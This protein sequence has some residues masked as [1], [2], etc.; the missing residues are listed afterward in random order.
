MRVREL[1][2]II[3]LRRKMQPFVDP[4]LQE[5]RG[6]NQNRRAAENGKPLPAQAVEQ[7]DRYPDRNEDEHDACLELHAD[8]GDQ[9]HQ[10]EQQ[11][12][13]NRFVALQ[14]CIQEDRQHDQRQP[15]RIGI[16]DRRIEPEW[17]IEQQKAAAKERKV[18]AAGALNGKEAQHGGRQDRGAVQ[19]HRPLME[20]LGTDVRRYPQNDPCKQGQDQQ[21]KLIVFILR[22][23]TV[24]DRAFPACSTERVDVQ[25]RKVPCVH[26]VCQPQPIGKIQHQKQRNGAGAQEG[27]RQN[28]T[29]DPMEQ[30]AAFSPHKQQGKK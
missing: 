17:R 30:R 6:K 26:A 14:A 21:K 7:Q 16:V 12:V 19:R 23:I 4:C 22:V 10:T 15:E 18:R 28:R 8:G 25:P 1:R 9:S 3:V 13:S 2:L 11:N 24:I 29:G 5:Q 20:D 27:A